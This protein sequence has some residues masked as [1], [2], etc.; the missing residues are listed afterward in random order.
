MQD[1]PQMPPL[2]PIFSAAKPTPYEQMLLTLAQAESLLYLAS[3]QCEKAEC[4]FRHEIGE[5]I[6]LVAGQ[7]ASTL[8]FARKP[9]EA[10]DDDPKFARDEEWYMEQ[11]RE[12]GLL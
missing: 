12:R 7:V 8:R 6:D 4:G 3:A 5:L 11:A 9:P 1:L 10:T 2:Q